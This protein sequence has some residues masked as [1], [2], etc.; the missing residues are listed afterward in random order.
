MEGSVAPDEEALR[1]LSAAIHDRMRDVLTNAASAEA[2]IAEL[3]YITQSAAGANH[4][5]SLFWESTRDTAE[6]AAAAAA[7]RFGNAVAAVAA[8]E[9]RLAALLA[10][11]ERVKSELASARSFCDI[12]SRAAQG[13]VD[14]R[15]MLDS[16]ETSSAAGLL[17]VV[18]DTHQA[19]DARCA[20]LSD[21]ITRIAVI[22]TAALEGELVAADAALERLLDA[23]EA[24]GAS[25]PAVRAELLVQYGPPPLLP[26]EPSGMQIVAPLQLTMWS[27]LAGDSSAASIPG[28]PHPLV[29]LLIGAAHPPMRCSGCGLQCAVSI[30]QCAPCSYKLCGIC[31][32]RVSAA[33][34]A[35]AALK[36]AVHCHALSRSTC[37]LSQ[38]K[39]ERCSICTSETPLTWWECRRC[40][41][42]EC[43]LC[44]VRT[45]A[46]FESAAAWRV[47]EAAAVERLAVT[48]MSGPGLHDEPA[49]LCRATPP[50]VIADVRVSRAVAA[51]DVSLR[52]IR[53]LPWVRLGTVFSFEVIY[54]L[55]CA[56]DGRTLAARLHVGAKLD[57]ELE[58]TLRASSH[59]A[60]TDEPSTQ[61]LPQP[62]RPVVRIA[63]NQ[64]GDGVCVRVHLPAELPSL[65]C[66]GSWRLAFPEF[67]LGA[68]P[69]ATGPYLGAGYA[70][71]DHP[72]PGRV[73]PPGNLFY[74][75]RFN[76][77]ENVKAYLATPDDG[78]AYSTEETDARGN[79]C[80]SFALQH[81][82]FDMAMLLCAAGANPLAAARSGCTFFQLACSVGNFDAIRF[83][84]ARTCSGFPDAIP[85]D[86]LIDVVGSASHDNSEAVKLLLADLRFEVNPRRPRGVTPVE[87]AAAYGHLLS[88][89]ALL[90]DARVR[91][92][93]SALRFAASNGHAN[94]VQL[95]LADA[96]TNMGDAEANCAAL[97]S[98]VTR[99]RVDVVRILLADQRVVCC[100]DILHWAT[101]AAVAR[102]LLSDTRGV[103][104]N[105]RDSEG[106]TPLF[107]AATRGDSGVMAAL[108][109]HPS[110]DVNARSLRGLSPLHAAVARSP[111]WSSGVT[112]PLLLAAPGIDVGTQRPNGLT[113]LIEAA[114]SGRADLVRMLLS[115]PGV[116][117]NAQTAGGFSALHAATY[118]NRVDVLRILLRDPHI[119]VNIQTR[120]GVTPLAGA[121]ARGLESAVGALLADPRVDVMRV[122][123]SGRS[124]IDVA[125]NCF[126]G[127]VSSMLLTDPRCT[128]MLSS[129]R[130]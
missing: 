70:A 8:L 96:R 30:R 26:V 7:E 44:F 28:H 54:P 72:P 32:D 66:G 128:R 85:R 6:I 99:G 29:L 104:V 49:L 119:I 117:V 63:A 42:V 61:L 43:E 115:H 113:P 125:R 114:R 47:R 69:I 129:R 23:T 34:A 64:T 22:K 21:A 97:T 100:A 94:V 130:S 68:F 41:H 87:Y 116:N 102:L 120:A 3:R 40:L 90:A 60:A 20:D 107:V 103:D 55:D 52:N 76:N 27:A 127:G 4:A 39:K 31:F 2:Q 65:P 101:N 67:F 88:I 77:I 50:L 89:R 95:L 108:L 16:P 83:L 9:S 105:A 109:A 38:G 112:V 110:V 111:A 15:R 121:A 59:A 37:M 80:L 106:R 126:R 98:A 33:A 25:V 46:A 48:D 24:G 10:E 78:S 118:S 75:C 51:E 71:V 58:P 35:V 93:P 14:A 17:A 82:N 73:S 122:D 57:P 86:G 124:A 5:D 45:V 84:Y 56:L 74:A 123:M 13:A 62:I 36:R 81:R 12:A 91:I 19:I 1:S 18:S 79:T 53:T 92:E 11:T